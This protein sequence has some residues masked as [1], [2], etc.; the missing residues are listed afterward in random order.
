M[1]AYRLGNY[2]LARFAKPASEHGAALGCF[3]ENTLHFTKAEMGAAGCFEHYLDEITAPLSKAFTFKYARHDE[4]TSGV[5]RKAL[6]GD[7]HCKTNYATCPNKHATIIRHDILGLNL[8]L[9][10]GLI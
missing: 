3:P 9:I 4:A 1:A 8:S 7:G 10:L 6:I 5:A 2:A